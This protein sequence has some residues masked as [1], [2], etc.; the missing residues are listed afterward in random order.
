MALMDKMKTQASVLASKAQEGLQQA[1]QQ[2]KSKLDQAQANRRADQMFR[3]L[4]AA[5]Y[6]ERTG[7]GGPDN[8]GKID[9]LVADLQAHEAEHGAS[10]SATVPPEE[11][12][13]DTGD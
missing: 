2:G 11:P 10:G 3:S 13:S 6:A 1:A 4:G 8:Q 5:V 7:R 9:K 12:S